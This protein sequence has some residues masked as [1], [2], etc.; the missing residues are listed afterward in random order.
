MHP[1][2]RTIL[3]HCDSTLLTSNKP[4]RKKNIFNMIIRRGSGWC[5]SEFGKKSDWRVSLSPLDLQEEEK[6][7][8]EEKRT[9]SA[10]PRSTS[11][12]TSPIATCIMDKIPSYAARHSFVFGAYAMPDS[13]SADPERTLD[14]L[15]DLLDVHNHDDCACVHGG[16]STAKAVHTRTHG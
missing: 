1:C 7:F 4:T 5:I 3:I 11:A 10:A 9:S 2:A 16:N 8:V 13:S 15:L 6:R 14:C 12:G